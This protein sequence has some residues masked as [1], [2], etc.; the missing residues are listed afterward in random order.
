MNKLNDLKLSDL[1][2]HAESDIFLGDEPRLP[3]DIFSVTVKIL[4]ITTIYLLRGEQ[5]NEDSKVIGRVELPLLTRGD[6]G[7]ALGYRGAGLKGGHFLGSVSESLD[8]KM[9]EI[10][11]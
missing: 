7:P 4:G 1:R 10:I 3:E 2:K 9:L 6:E 5:K 8:A 11:G